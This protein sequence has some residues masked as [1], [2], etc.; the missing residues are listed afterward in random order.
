MRE[1]DE[2]KALGDVG[3]AAEMAAYH[4]TVR[5]YLGVA[6]PVID[7]LARGWRAGLDVPARVDLARRLWD[8][9]VH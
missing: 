4:K 1:L 3:K 8:S 7:A 5:P 6:V 9:D 2:L